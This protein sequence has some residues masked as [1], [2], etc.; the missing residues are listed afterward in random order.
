MKF[1]CDPNQRGLCCIIQ[2]TIKV[3][4]SKDSS[5][6]MVLNWIKMNI[7][8]INLKNQFSITWLGNFDKILYIQY[9][10]YNL[11]IMCVK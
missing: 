9:I 2:G 1:L 4:E 5:I 7:L 6:N 11:Y 3:L 8:H 10:I